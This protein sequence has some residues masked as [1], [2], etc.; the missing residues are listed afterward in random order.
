MRICSWDR[1]ACF[2]DSNA[3]YP[4]VTIRPCITRNVPANPFAASSSV[5]NKFVR[6]EK[7]KMYGSFQLDSREGGAE[8]F[9]ETKQNDQVETRN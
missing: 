7:L 6:T 4:R 5:T 3:P 2:G 8:W 1:K 9:G